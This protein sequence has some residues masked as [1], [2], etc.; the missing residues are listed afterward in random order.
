MKLL[1]DEANIVQSNDLLPLLLNYDSNLHEELPEIDN[2]PS[3]PSE[4]EDKVFN[5]GIL[6]H[7]STH[8]VTNKVT[9]DKNL[10][11]KTS[12]EEPLILKERKVTFFLSD[13]IK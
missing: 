7:G 5:P 11:E 6:V 8:F 2:F 10:K 13:D 4:N 3:F 12:S 9:H 1:I